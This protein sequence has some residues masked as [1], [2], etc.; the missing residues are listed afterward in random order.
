MKTCGSIK[1]SIKNNIKLVPKILKMGT[2]NLFII[3]MSLKLI[4]L[5]YKNI[6]NYFE[7]YFFVR[8]KIVIG[9]IEY[10]LLFLF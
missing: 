6:K 4:H 1:Y 2:N 8:E 5:T 9:Q 7:Y 3:I 10:S